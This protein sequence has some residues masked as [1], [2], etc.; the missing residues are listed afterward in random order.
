MLET[1]PRQ[2]KRTEATTPISLRLPVALIDRL[3]E[4]ARAGDRSLNAQIER[5]LR[6]SIEREKPDAK[7]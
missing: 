2:G 5:M 3:R 7:D 4:I 6:A 1:V